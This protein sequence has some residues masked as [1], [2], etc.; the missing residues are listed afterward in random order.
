MTPNAAVAALVYQSTRS[1]RRGEGHGDQ[2]ADPRRAHADPPPVGPQL[3]PRGL[4]PEP[5]VD[6]GQPLPAVDGA[7]GRVGAPRRR[8]GR[9]PRAAPTTL[10][11]ATQTAIRERL[12]PRQLELETPACS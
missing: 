6:P 1:V 7:D 11:P 5:L 12:T 8:A 9:G 2:A 10:A 3:A 4:L